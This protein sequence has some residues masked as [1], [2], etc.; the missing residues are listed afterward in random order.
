MR[1]AADS[2]RVLAAALMCRAR[3]RVAAEGFGVE[4]A[5]VDSVA[6]VRRALV[7]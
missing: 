6:S 1:S 2:M 3:P 4:R 5:Q 7:G